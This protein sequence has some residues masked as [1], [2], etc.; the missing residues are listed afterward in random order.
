MREA[1]I[2][3]EIDVPQ[4]YTITLEDVR[5]ALKSMKIN[6]APGPDNIAA[7]VIKAGGEKMIECLHILY[8]IAFNS[9][10]VPADWNLSYICTFFKKRRP[11]RV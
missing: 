7:E 6:K 11:N 8:N 2:D 10:M 1:E 4:E 3:M 5:L 9:G